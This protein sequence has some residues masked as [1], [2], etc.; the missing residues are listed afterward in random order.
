MNTTRRSARSAEAASTLRAPTD[1]G[2]HTPPVRARF[3]LSGA[4]AIACSTSQAQVQ[5]QTQARLPG[6]ETAYHA[7]QASDP[8][9]Q[10]ARFTLDIA[11]QKLPEARASLMPVVGLSGGINAVQANTTFSNLPPIERSGGENT[12]TLQLTQPLFRIDNLLATQQAPLIIESAQAQ[13]EQAEQDLLLRVAQAYFAVNEARDAIAAADAQIAAMTQQ[14]QEVSKG[15]NAG[16][17]AVT[18][19]DDTK[20]RLGTAQAQQIAARNDLDNARADLDRLTGTSYATLAELNPDTSLPAPQPAVIADWVAQARDNQPLVRAQ[21]AAVQVASLDV[22]RARSGHIPTIDFVANVGHNFSNHSLTTPDDYST[23]AAQHAVGIQVNVPLFA[24]GAIVSKV[25]QA[26]SALNKARSDLEAASR[27]AASDAQ[28]A[29][30]GVTS[31]LA[32]VASL[33]TAVQA[34]NSALTGNKAGFRVGYRTNVD[35][36]NAEQQLFAS[37]RDLSKARYDVL[38][39]G[40]KLKAAAGILGEHDLAAIDSLL[41]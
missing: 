40:M 23:K 16:I 8:T 32:Q 12:W 28:H 41:H 7:A 17:R 22:D 1:F 31:G 5:T 35:V 14:L 33:V 21:R 3:L 13:Y 27:S 2:I 6:L 4:M 37:Q 25:S 15:F 18:D 36:L 20:A 34:G 26:E 30:T 19:V 38:L 29:Y 11:L 9:I 10:A 24:G 39:Q